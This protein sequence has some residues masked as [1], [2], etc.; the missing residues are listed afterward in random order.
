MA[1]LKIIVQQID[2]GILLGAPLPNMPSLLPTIAAKLNCACKYC[3]K[4][5]QLT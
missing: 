4:E 2:K 3:N 5:M 1:L